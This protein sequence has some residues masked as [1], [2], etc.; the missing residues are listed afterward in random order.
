MI[1]I[2]F[3]ENIEERQIPNED[4]LPFTTVCGKFLYVYLKKHEDSADNDSPY[5]VIQIE[6]DG[7]IGVI[8]FE[9]FKE[10]MEDYMEDYEENEVLVDL[11]IN[12][13]RR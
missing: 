13:K 6:E 11:E 10:M 4:M 9:T 3:E 8:P 2:N 7:D 5:T 1:T 12:I